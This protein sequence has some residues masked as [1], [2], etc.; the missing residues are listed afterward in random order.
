MRRP[1]GYGVVTGP[2]G[3]IAEHDTATCSHC[4]AV[5]RVG[6]RLGP[7]DIGGLC[8]VCMGLICPKC[9]EAGH[10]RPFEK[11]LEAWEA[12]GA[13]LRSYGLG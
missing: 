1:G 7:E 10:C 6:A 9:T 2:E 3:V 11:Q 12:R 8:K 5:F 4:N 13:A